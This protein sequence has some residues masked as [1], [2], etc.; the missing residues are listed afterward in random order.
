M[1][2]LLDCVEIPANQAPH[3]GSIVWLHG[4]G[5][6]GHDFEPIVPHLGLDDVRFVFPHA[7]MLPVTING[8]LVMPAWYDITELDPSGPR[9][10]EEHIRSSAKHVEA[11][12]RRE[13]ER[14]VPARRIVLAGFSQGGAMALHVGLRHPERLAG[15]LVLSG[16]LVL[17]DRLDEERSEANRD[18]PMLFCHGRF[19]QVV[20]PLLGQQAFEAVKHD[21]DAKLLMFPIQHEVSLPEVATVAKWLRE[22]LP[23][24]T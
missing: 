12:I 15:V 10:S 6:S 11:L 22:R 20:P 14:G 19:D 23:R 24:D 8:G 16:Y 3:A 7:P 2:D 13:Q 5:A 1:G 9:E 21:R 17:R 18:T 4:L